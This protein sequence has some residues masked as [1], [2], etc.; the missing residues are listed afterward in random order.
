MIACSSASL[1]ALS[2]ASISAILAMLGRIAFRTRAFLVPKIFF[3]IKV[4]MGWGD[5]RQPSMSGRRQ[6][7]AH[8]IA[9]NAR[10][11]GNR[12]VSV[13]ASPGGRRVAPPAARRGPARLDGRG[14]RTV[15]PE[16]AILV[17]DRDSPD[18]TGVIADELA[19]AETPVAPGY[20]QPDG[21]A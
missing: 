18:G 21:S 12:T 11:Q 8:L 3:P 7:A 14:A 13:L 4:S 20:R 1:L 9:R 6:E 16:A 19:G 2:P 5:P 10:V 17:V 15:V